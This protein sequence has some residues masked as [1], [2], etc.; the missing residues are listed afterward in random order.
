MVLIVEP[1]SRIA[2]TRPHDDVFVKIFSISIA[3]PD[4]LRGTEGKLSSLSD[5]L[6]DSKIS[7]LAL[8]EMWNASKV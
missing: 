6:R 1:V 7:V 3:H 4:P 2:L 8:R 5:Y